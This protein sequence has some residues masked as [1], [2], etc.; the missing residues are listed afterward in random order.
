MEWHNSA[1]ID[2]V[3]WASPR[4]FKQK[5]ISLPH[6]NTLI[7]P[8]S[9]LVII[10]TNF[11]VFQEFLKMEGFHNRDKNCWGCS[12]SPNPKSQL[13]RYPNCEAMRNNDKQS[14][15]VSYDQWGNTLQAAATLLGLLE[16]TMHSISIIPSLPVQEWFI[17]GS[18]TKRFAGAAWLFG[19]FLKR[20]FTDNVSL[21]VNFLIV[22]QARH[23]KGSLLV[24]ATIS[25]S[26]RP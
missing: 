10:G 17:F 22:R 9:K 6:S 23:Y 21:L 8:P 1:Y 5:L 4:Q 11:S 25:W 18:L 2:M 26:R 13:V 12:S 24:W 20:Q 16:T 7:Y 3:Y 14:C 15:V 19:L